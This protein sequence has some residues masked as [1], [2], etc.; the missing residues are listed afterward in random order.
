MLDSMDKI[1]DEADTP[2]K[3]KGQIKQSEDCEMFNRIKLGKKLG[4]GAYGS[5]Y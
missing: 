4:E 3:I 2:S 1:E 5:V